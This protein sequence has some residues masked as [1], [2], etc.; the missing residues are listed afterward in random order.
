MGTITSGI[1]LVSG[2]DTTSIISQ[3]IALE[4]QPVTILQARYS[5]ATAQKQAF[6]GLSTQLSS[7]QQIGQALELPQTFA[8]SSTNSSDPNVL[9]ATATAGAAV[10]SYQ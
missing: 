2:I 5:T 7:L 6:T 4:Q 9:T 10:G 1:G 8:A 3:L